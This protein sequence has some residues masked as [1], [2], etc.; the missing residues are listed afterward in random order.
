MLRQFAP[1]KYGLFVLV[2][3][4]SYPFNLA[5]SWVPYKRE[6]TLCISHESHIGTP[7]KYTTTGFAPRKKENGWCIP[8]LCV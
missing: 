3:Y 2:R 1:S 6:S 5:L 8:F 4:L 7:Y